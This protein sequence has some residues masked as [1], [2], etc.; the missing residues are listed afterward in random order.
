VRERGFKIKSEPTAAAAA[1]GMHTKEEKKIKRKRNKL[2]YI[3]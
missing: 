2:G 1:A 3:G